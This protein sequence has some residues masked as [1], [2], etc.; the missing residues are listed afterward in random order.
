MADGDGRFDAAS[1]HS[2]ASLASF[3]ESAET[4]D[5]SPPVAD[6]A[7]PSTSRRIVRAVARDAFR[8]LCGAEGL[9]GLSVEGIEASDP[10]NCS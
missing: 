3:W 8:D 7:S 4:P 1:L 6:A 10:W 9:S 2:E 5:V